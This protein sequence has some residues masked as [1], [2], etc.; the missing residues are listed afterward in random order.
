MPLPADKAAM[1]NE[2]AA[3]TGPQFDRLYGRYQRD[4]HE[5]TLNLYRSYAQNG[6]DPTLVSYAQ[7]VIPH[8][9][10]HLAATRN[11]PGATGRMR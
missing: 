7:S 8:L 2:L 3:T 5:Q 10:Q 9:E 11:L 1:L 6:T 4:A